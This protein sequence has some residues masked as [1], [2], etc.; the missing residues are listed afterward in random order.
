MSDGPRVSRRARNKTAARRS[1]VM[2]I[3]GARNWP[4]TLDHFVWFLL[5]AGVKPE[6]IAKS[7]GDSVHRHRYTKA[8]AVPRPQ[9][10]EY[11]RVI[12]EWMRDPLYLDGY[13]NTLTLPV[14]GAR[15]SFRSLVRKALPHEDAE[16]VLRVL[17]R[18]EIVRRV[19]TRRVQ[20]LADT[21]LPNGQE[22]AQFLA[23]TL[24]ALEGIIDT[25][26][27]NLTNHDPK[28]PGQVQRLVIAERFDMSRIAEYDTYAR[29]SAHAMLA[30]HD[31]WLKRREING[32]IRGKGRVGYVG[33][34]IFGFKAR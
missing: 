4:K 30:K 8:L 14:S 33:V 23:Y 15:L 1:S 25:C 29:K 27:A 9:V 10:L 34:G 5:R 6:Q 31:A 13:G 32:P 7:M 28:K 22:Q 3:D 11:S 17:S 2:R 21:F 18:H 26:H 24:S 20:L 19:P 16:E 12:T